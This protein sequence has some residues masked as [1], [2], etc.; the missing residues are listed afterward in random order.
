M[1]GFALPSTES[2][3]EVESRARFFWERTLLPQISS[4][5]RVMCV[6]HA[7]ILKALMKVIDGLPP[8]P[9]VQ[10]AIISIG[11]PRATPIVFS[12]NE[13]M[14]S[15]WGETAEEK[16]LPRL[17]PFSGVLQPGVALPRKGGDEV[18]AY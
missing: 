3:V 9:E 1:V 13:N 2:M 17:K 14:E 18:N 6:A 15:L 12:F 16:S 10:D 5:K 8:T 7:N 4:G 11:I